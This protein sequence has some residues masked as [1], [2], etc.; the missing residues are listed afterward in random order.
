VLVG[1]LA[2]G[3]LD[4]FGL[5]RLRPR[6]VWEKHIV[7]DR[8]RL[9]FAG[10]MLTL[11]TA[12]LSPLDTLSDYLFSADMLQHMMLIYVAPPLL[13]LGT[14][15]WLLRPAL[16]RPRAA[17]RPRH[18]REPAVAALGRVRVHPDRCPARPE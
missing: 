18:V 11:A 12:L 13:L 2:I 5:R 9:L 4:F 8:E 7:S 16:P 1:L 15:A 14:P 17:G 6:T 3:A 10:G